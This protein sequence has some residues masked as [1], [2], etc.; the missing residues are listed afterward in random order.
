MSARR[1]GLVAGAQ[2][3][4]VGRSLVCAADVGTVWMSAGISAG[5]KRMEA[6]LTSKSEE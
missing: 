4:P 6:S 3:V 2:R 1:V 5:V